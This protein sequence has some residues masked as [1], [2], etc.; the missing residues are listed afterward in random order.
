MALKKK[1]NTSITV[2]G[3]EI[4]IPSIYKVIPK[5]DAGAPDG[6]V[7]NDTTKLLDPKIG[8]SVPLAIWDS[9][10]S[11]WDTGL[12]MSS[13]QLTRMYPDTK[14][15]QTVVDALKELIIKPVEQ[16]KGEGVLSHIYKKGELSYYDKESVDLRNGNTFNTANPTDLFALYASIL[17]GNLAPKD[18]EEE[19]IFRTKAQYAVQNIEQTVGL[20]QRKD[21]ERNE[22]IGLFFTMLNNNKVDLLTILDYLGIPST[23]NPDKGSLNSIFTDWLNNKD[24]GFQNASIFVETYEKF[25]TAEGKEEL[26][27]FATLKELLRKGLLKRKMGGVHLDDLDL[28][29]N[30][31]I[32]ARTALKSDEI[33]EAIFNKMS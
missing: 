33:K 14:Q 27:I 22:A 4:N 5:L 11:I 13:R 8:T 23:D 10:R 15:R 12:D 20:K 32:A 19:P 26:S 29:A 30:L 6:F 31:K 28:G 25:Q 9:D 16:I 17:H 21:L 7:A 24:S 3:Y 1:E 18:R 2:H